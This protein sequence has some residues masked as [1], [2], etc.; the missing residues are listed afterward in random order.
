MVYPKKAKTWVEIS[1][2]ALISNIHI[3][4]KKIGDCTF[5]AVVKSNAYGHGL[6]EIAK[7]VDKAGI[8]WFGVDNV[9]EGIALRR[10]GIQK[11][12]LV[13]G[14]TPNNRLNDCIQ[15]GISFVVYNMKTIRKLK[16]IKTT[17]KIFV[18]IPIETGTTRQGVEGDEL[19]ALV[20]EIKKNPKIVIEGVSTHYA[21]IE[22]THDTAYATQQLKRYQNAL[23][24]L[25]SQGINPIWKHTAASA[26]AILFP[27]TLF[28]MARIGIAL[29]G[30]RSSERIQL[31][32]K[33]VLTWKTIIAQIKDVKKN[34]PV[35]YGLTERVLR[36][37]RI[38]VIPIGYWDGF[39]RKLSSKAYVSIHGKPCKIIGRV[40]M[41]MCMV[42]ITNV[43]RA[44]VDDVVIL[45][46]ADEMAHIVQTINYEIVTRINPLIQKIIVP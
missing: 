40:C 19:H 41:N 15:N 6:I 36:D 5:M 25:K 29:Y 17:K 38:A 18:H 35:S 12:I 20:Q 37:S 43:P 33:R 1:R 31:P 2:S 3:L 44:R 42:D 30:L 23:Q 26:A 27:E 13:L 8:P 9:D 4:Q 14:Y 22:D 24:Q 34:T 16:S 21:N 7:I 11:K 46:T 10:A 28:D 32:L 39:D 45:P